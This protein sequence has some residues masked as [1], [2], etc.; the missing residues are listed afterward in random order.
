MVARCSNIQC[1]RVYWRYRGDFPPRGYCST[2]CH[3]TRRRRADH[4]GESL[5][6]VIAAIQR[7]RW[8]AHATR[9][10]DA[11]FDCGECARLEERQA[12]AAGVAV[13]RGSEATCS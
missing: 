12:Q 1:H 11:W 7:H 13:W 8:E 6:C 5:P 4:S 3:D 2:L 10:P 9:D